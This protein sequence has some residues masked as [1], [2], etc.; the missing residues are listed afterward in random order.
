MEL[1]V[2]YY[3]PDGG[4]VFKDGS[5]VVNANFVGGDSGTIIIKPEMNDIILVDLVSG[6]VPRRQRADF[7]NLVWITGRTYSLNLVNGGT[8]CNLS[9]EEREKRLKLYQEVHNRILFG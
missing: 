8:R 9:D 7:F 6:Q 1:V 5:S 2:Y 3:P 4:F